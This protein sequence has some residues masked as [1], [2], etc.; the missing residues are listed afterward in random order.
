M[1]SDETK[2]N[3]SF[4]TTSS[5]YMKQFPASFRYYEDNDNDTYVLRIELEN[6]SDEEM[7]KSQSLCSS[8]CPAAVA[9]CCTP[10][11]QEEAYY[12]VC[13]D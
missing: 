12:C 1:N 9:N 3:G 5:M 2:N 7:I 6:D 4:K 10:S 13:P 11:P 8:S